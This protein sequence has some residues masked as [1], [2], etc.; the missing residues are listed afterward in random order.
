MQ[1][2]TYRTFY[3]AENPGLFVTKVSSRSW[4]RLHTVSSDDSDA[5]QDALVPSTARW[6]GRESAC[7][8]ES[9]TPR[10]CCSGRYR[11]LAPLMMRARPCASPA[12]SATS[13]PPFHLR[14]PVF[15]SR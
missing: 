15:D 1:G 4:L 6:Q 3:L 14:S 11:V 12:T 2:L 5:P 10:S 13:P 8:G 7:P 9:G